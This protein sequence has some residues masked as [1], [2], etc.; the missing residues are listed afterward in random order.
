M[1][2]TRSAVFPSENG[3]S[4]MLVCTCSV[5]SGFPCASSGCM[6]YEN[7]WPLT[8]FVGVAMAGSLNGIGST[9]CSPW[10]PVYAIVATRLLYGCHCKSRLQFSEYGNVFFGSYPPKRNAKFANPVGVHVGVTGSGQ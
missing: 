9:S 6:P 10:F 7:V 4:P 5:T 3:N 2:G 8:G 1:K